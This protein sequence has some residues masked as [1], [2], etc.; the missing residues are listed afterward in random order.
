MIDYEKK[1]MIPLTKKEK[2]MHRRQKKNAVYAKKYLVL[3][4]TIKNTIKYKIIAI[5]LENTEVLLKISAI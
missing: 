2:K 3:I 5:I 4:I 1:E